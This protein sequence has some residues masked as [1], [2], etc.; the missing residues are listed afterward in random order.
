MWKNLK[1]A[2]KQLIDTISA[3]NQKSFGSQRMDCCD[4]N[5]KKR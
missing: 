1:K 3:Q 2:L 4:L 5:K